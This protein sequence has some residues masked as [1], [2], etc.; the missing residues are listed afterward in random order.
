[1]EGILAII[2]IFIGF[3]IFRMVISAI[4]TTVGAAGK[5]LVGK[6]DFKQNMELGFKGMQSFDVQVI[7]STFESDGVSLPIKQIQCK[8][9]FPVSKPVNASV[10]ISIFDASGEELVPILAAIENFQEESSPAYQT[11]SEV[12]LIK[13]NQG[14]THWVN[15]GGVFPE[16]LE[17][18]YSGNRDIKIIVRLVDNN[19]F[20]SI[21]H[22]FNHSNDGILWQKTLPISMYFKDKGY[23]EVADDR[24]ESKALSIKIA[25]GVAMSDGSLDKEEAEVFKNWIVKSIEPFTGSRK[26][27][28]KDI[29]NSALKDS[30]ASSREGTFHLDS[31]LAR[32]NKIADKG[33]K[34]ETIELC[35]DI[36]AADGVADS[37]E[38]DAI[39]SIATYLGL[40]MEEISKMRDQRI[41]NLNSEA[42]SAS[43]L[44]DL[45]GI[46][47]DWSTKDIKKHLRQEFQKW[48]NRLN[49]LEE[50]EQRDNA[51]LMLDRISEARKKYQ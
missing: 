5:T 19:N 6:G 42:E 7:D 38:L 20:P 25:M 13:D 8:G 37:K 33:V 36:M 9:L 1:M 30:F 46:E 10:V 47:A 49:A 18:P 34:Y 31:Y 2:A 39:K 22:G 28:L 24:D 32:M 15:L 29:L 40:N 23:I 26:I 44:E 43:S 35:F 27:E 41:V 4:F 11:I 12:G 45:L 16:I 3:A 48:N 21:H 51:Q 50:G 17:P 14:F